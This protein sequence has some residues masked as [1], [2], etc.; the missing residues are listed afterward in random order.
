MLVVR[1]SA[2][3]PTGTSYRH[4]LCAGDSALWASMADRHSLGCMPQYSHTNLDL[5]KFYFRFETW[6][7]VTVT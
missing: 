1:L 7:H 5:S 3:A 6:E 2:F 4:L